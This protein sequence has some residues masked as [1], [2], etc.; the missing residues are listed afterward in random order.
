MNRIRFVGTV[1]TVLLMN[2]IGSTAWGIGGTQYVRFQPSKGVFPLSESGTKTTLCSNTAD[3]PGVIRALGDL[4]TDIGKVT[5]KEPELVM[6]RIPKNGQVVLVGTVGKSSLIDEL[7]ESGKLDVSNIRGKWEHFIIKVVK[8]PLPGLKQALVV[9]GSDKRGTIYGIYDISEK[10]GVSPWYYWADVSIKHQENLYVQPV[11]VVEGPSV[12]YRGIFLNDE[13]PALS[14]WMEMKYGTLPVQGL[15]HSGIANYGREFYCDLFELL[16]RIKANYL[17]PAMWNNAFNE[18][19]PEN[20]RLADEY[21]IVM[22]TSHQEPMVRAQKEWDRRYQ[23]TLGSWDYTKHPEVMQTFWREGIQRNK[24]FESIV[25]MGLRG[26]NDSEMKGT[27]KDNIAMVEGII[28]VQQDILVDEMKKPLEE[29]PQAWCLYKEINDYYNE[30]MKVPDNI[31]L[32]WADDNWG[33]VRRLPNEEERQRKGGAGVYYHFDYHGGPRSYEWI[34]TN[35]LPRIWDQMMLSKQYGADKIWVVNVGHF[36]GYE[37]PIEYFVNLGWNT[38]RWTNDNITE[39][40]RLWAEREFGPKHA[41]DIADILAKYAKFN[42]RRKPESLTPR[43]YS[44]T[45][46]NEAENVVAE[47]NALSKKAETIGAQLPKEYQDAYYHLVL[48]PTKVC[49]ILNDMYLAAG[50]NQLYAKQGRASAI[51]MA[52]RTRMLF[53][54]DTTMMTEYNKVYAQGRWN[55]FMD[56]THIGY[57]SWNPPKKNSLSAIRLTENAIPEAAGLGVALEGTEDAWPGPTTNAT[58]PRFD[59]FGSEERWMEVFNRGKALLSYEIKS[60]LPWLRFSETSGSLGAADKRILVKL[61]AEKLPE[62][63]SSSSFVVTGAGQTVTVQVSAFKP[64]AK[65]R[66]RVKGFVESNG[67]VS[68]EA[69]HLTKNRIAGDRKWIRV[70]DYGLTLSGMRATA[71]ANAAPATPGTDAPC[72]EYPIYLFSKDSMFVHLITSPVLNF[73]PGRDIR[74]AVSLNN[75]KPL[76]LTVVPASFSVQTSRS[77]NTD[78]VNQCRRL[79]T[80]IK[81]PKSGAQTLKVWMVDPG[82]VLQKVVLTSGAYPNTYLGPTESRFI[83]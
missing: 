18:D 43:T 60:D 12:Q 74:I 41:V 28:K 65:E 48:F 22:G 37:L 76:Y 4:K 62:G 20:A 69:E 2:A 3:Y 68:I 73:M 78:V 49:A 34:N 47:Y 59:L 51:E 46:F 58:L 83:K 42:T 67:I 31:T 6:D 44:L 9:A 8:N 61:I 27:M 30:G 45:Q 53:S 24:D 33:Y 82:V 15:F 5:G 32:L 55:H 63:L 72:L 29:I 13:A 80:T 21:G 75:D 70:E 39:Y 36:R 64:S 10:I 25:T 52:A 19:D 40:T 35:P 81:I 57:T 77:W 14:G 66:S 79:T 17:W 71:P 7:V 50:K 38:N 23:R 16:L 54:A 56:Q 1:L 11:T 26:A